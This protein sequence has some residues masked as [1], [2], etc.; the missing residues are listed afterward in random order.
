VVTRTSIV[1]RPHAAAGLKVIA[2]LAI[3]LGRPNAPADY[4]EPTGKSIAD[5]LRISQGGEVR[6]MIVANEGRD[7]L[8]CDGRRGVEYER[9]HR[10]NRGDEPERSPSHDNRSAIVPVADRSTLQLLAT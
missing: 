5:R 4:L 3:L 2:K 9:E 8:F 6:I 10:S 1:D 7:A